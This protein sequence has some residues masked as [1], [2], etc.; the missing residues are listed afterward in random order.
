[1]PKIIFSIVYDSVDDVEI[2]DEAVIRFKS[3]NK[4]ANVNLYEIEGKNF[5]EIEEELSRNL[6]FFLKSHSEA[7]SSMFKFNKE[8]L[9]E[10]DEFG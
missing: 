1:M 2:I 3:S 4:K 9:D 6:N 7:A 8:K 5:K 10:M